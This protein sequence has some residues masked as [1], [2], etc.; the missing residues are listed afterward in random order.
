[1]VEKQQKVFISRNT[2]H[3]RNYGFG[4]EFSYQIVSFAVT[5]SREVTKLSAKTLH[6]VDCHCFA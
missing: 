1:M 6:C 2:E 4:Q 5:E 3:A